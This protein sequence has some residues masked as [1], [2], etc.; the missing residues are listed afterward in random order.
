MRNN[1]QSMMR[2]NRARSGTTMPAIFST[3]MT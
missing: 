1:S 3:F 2:M